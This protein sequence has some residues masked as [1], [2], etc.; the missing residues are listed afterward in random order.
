MSV[1]EPH[2]SAFSVVLSVR[3]CTAQLH[4]GITATTCVYCLAPFHPAVRPHLTDA[5]IGRGKGG[6]AAENK[7]SK[8][9]AETPNARDARFQQL[10][11]LTPQCSTFT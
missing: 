8:A 3:Y 1:S 9:S 10:R 5:N 11:T 6:P 2:T 4:T 7:T